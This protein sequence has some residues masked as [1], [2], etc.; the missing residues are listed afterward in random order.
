MSFSPECFKWIRRLGS[1]MTGLCKSTHAAANELGHVVLR[2]G[3]PV[4]FQSDACLMVRRPGMECG[5][6][7]DVCPTAVLGGGLWSLTLEKAGCLGCG[8]CAA[9]CPTGAL[10]VD[11]FAIEP[12][13]AVDPPD[14]NCE[15]ASPVALECRRVPA[16]MCVKNSVKL[17]CLGG[18]TAPDLL[19]ALASGVHGINLM[20]RGWCADCGIAARPSPWAEHV[21][22]A[23]AV[24]AAVDQ[25]LADRLTVVSAPLPLEMALPVTELGPETQQSRR[26]FFRRLIAPKP[27]PHTPAESQQIVLGRGLVAPVARARM[28]AASEHLAESFEAEPPAAL[29]PSVTIATEACDLHGICAAIC[30]TGALRRVDENGTVFIDFDP[31][32]CISCKECARACPTKAVHFSPEGEGTWPTDRTVLSMRESGR[33]RSCGDIFPQPRGSRETLCQPC[34]RGQSLINDLMMIRNAARAC[35]GS[36]AASIPDKGEKV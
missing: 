20:N 13:D 31:G 8:L 11:G 5:A 1:E 33:C 9:E 18:L 2:Q 10:V 34:R 30:P 23:H 29:M 15:E 27:Q 25:T 26:E 4:R 21:A 28:L 3:D 24:L 16:G 35:P 19:E 36:L 12:A 6:C 22:A 14:Q 17:P 32:S 7:R